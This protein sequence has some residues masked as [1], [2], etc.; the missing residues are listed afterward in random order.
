M[1]HKSE[2]KP[3]GFRE[4]NEAEL[5]WVAGGQAQVAGPVAG[6]GSKI[7]DALVKGFFGGLGGEG[8]DAAVDS[9][10]GEDEATEEDLLE[11]EQAIN[12]QF[13][14]L[15]ESVPFQFTNASTGITIYGKYQDGRLFMDS[16]GNGAFDSVSVIGADGN[17]YIDTGDGRG[18]VGYVPGTEPWLT[19]TD[20]ADLVA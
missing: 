18:P 7:F 1:L 2:L 3:S 5:A 16:D 11:R 19:T 6:L 4:L 15:E 17:I 10:F 12:P 8:A 14:P 9:V 20:T 13:N